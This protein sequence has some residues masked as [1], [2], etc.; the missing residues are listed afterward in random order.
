MGIERATRSIE[1]EG[2]DLRGV[3]KFEGRVQIE[4]KR[5]E[6]RRGEERGVKKKKKKRRKRKEDWGWRTVE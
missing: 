4:F 2:S 5:E 3:F 1:V 6:E